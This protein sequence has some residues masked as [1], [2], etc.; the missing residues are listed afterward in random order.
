[1]KNITKT[2]I[3][4]LTTDNRD[5]HRR[6]D[7][8]EPYFGTA[9]EALLE[10]FSLLGNSQ[11]D[12]E[13]HVISCTQNYLIAPEKL[14]ENIWYHSLHVPKIGWLRTGYQGCIRAVRKKLR[15]IKPDIVHG[16]GTERDCALN[17]VFSGYP[18]VLT[19]HGNM[20]LVAKVNGA[21]PLSFL[22]ITSRLESLA[23]KKTHA[24]ICISNHTQ[25]AVKNVV[26]QTW[27]VPNAVDSTFFDITSDQSFSDIPT[28][29]CIG[30]I[31]HHKNQ[32]TLIQSL[33]KISN[34]RKLRMI[35]AGNVANDS[36]GLEFK[37]LI[38]N[39]PWCEH[40]GFMDRENIKKNL[41]KSTFLVLPSIED[42]C[43]MVIL[44]AMAAGI[45][46]VASNI[47]GIPDLIVHGSTGFLCDPSRP[48][49]FC[50]S[51]SQILGSQQM[52][53]SIASEAKHVAQK[54]FHPLVI[55]KEHLRIY[56]QVIQSRILHFGETK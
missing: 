24:V 6:Y 11:K 14:A 56:R 48:E 9:P 35:F 53:K 23:L 29:I 43:P 15:E 28:G 2:K 42:N 26:P 34:S 49:E 39:R 18:N 30:T 54:R 32:N 50:Q 12:F 31:C 36:Y 19:L 20:R 16:Q 38:K 5:A 51:I 13:I 41:R 40:V 33:D 21:K 44:E 1:M 45:P 25:H 7:C 27:I 22:W 17:A 55:A 4:F 52:K 3:A 37:K 46:V 10:G 47:G 8:L